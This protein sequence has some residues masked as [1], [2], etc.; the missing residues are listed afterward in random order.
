MYFDD[1]SFHQAFL[2]GRPSFAYRYI[3]HERDL[4]KHGLRRMIGNGA[5]SF[6]WT[7]QWVLDGVMC[8]LMKNV[9]F[10]LDLRVENL[11]DLTS[12]TWDLDSP[13]EHFYTRDVDL[14]LK[15]KSD[16]SS[17]DFFIWE[18]TKSGEYIVKSGYWFAYQREKADLICD[19]QMQ[20]SI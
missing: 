7:G 17:H 14:I 3:L 15:I 6:V 9:I 5:G 20:P 11:L 12:G 1:S 2:G 19:M 4:L 8:A 16:V 13:H 18:H 10:D